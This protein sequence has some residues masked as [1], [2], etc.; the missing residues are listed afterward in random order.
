MNSTPPSSQG[1][2]AAEGLGNRLL[3][4]LPAADLQRWRPHLDLV[5]MA[6][7]SPLS[8]GTDV[9]T[10]LVFPSTA[11][12]SLMHTTRDGDSLEV[13][14][15]GS[16][17]VVGLQALLGGGPTLGTTRSDGNMSGTTSTGRSADGSMSGNNERLNSDGSMRSA[18][19][20]RN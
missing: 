11:S 13:V 2:P 10:H 20:D 17:G 19:S 7:G 18:R 5:G 9:P 14:A 6:A 4:A 1:F 12:I 15:I 8:R 16:E 3:E